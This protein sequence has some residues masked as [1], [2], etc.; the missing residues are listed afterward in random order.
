MSFLMAIQARKRIMSTLEMMMA[1]RR[2]S[3]ANQQDFLQH[4][5]ACDKRSC[6]DGASKLSDEEIKD[7]ILTMII[8]GQKTLHILFLNYG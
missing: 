1:R 3:D 7:N 8:A 2:S 6:P 4:L 5:L